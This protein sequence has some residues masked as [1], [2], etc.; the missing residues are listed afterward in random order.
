MRPL[1]AACCVF[2]L[3]LPLFAA[4]PLPAKTTE[5]VIFADDRYDV[6]GWAGSPQ[7]SREFFVARGFKPLTAE[8]LAA[9]MAAKAAG[10]AYGTV[11]VLPTGLVPGPILEPG[12]WEGITKGFSDKK[13]F[14]NC[15]IRKYME[16]GGRVVFMG[17]V[18]FYYVQGAAG[19][20]R[21][22][23]GLMPQLADVTTDQA[24]LYGPPHHQQVLT[25]QGK[26]WG[27]TQ[28]WFGM[29][30]N[31]A[32]VTQT[33]VAAPT[34]KASLI[35]LKTLNPEYPLSGLLSFPIKLRADEINL[36]LLADI[37]KAA[38]YW[39][40]PVTV[41]EVAADKQTLPDLE[42]SVKLG[43]TG[44]R[45]VYLPEDPIAGLV[46]ITNRKEP[47]SGT[48]TIRFSDANGVYHNQEKKLGLPS[49]EAPVALLNIPT[50]GL[51]RGEY[52]LEVAFT[53]DTGQKVERPAAI[54][55][56]SK[57]DNPFFLGI[58]GELPANAFRR[59]QYLKEI[60]GYHLNPVCAPGYD[61]DLLRMGMRFV[62]RIE[63]YEGFPNAVDDKDPALLRRD[64]NGNPIANPWRPALWKVSIAHP[65]VI[66]GWSEGQR[67]QIRKLA[68]HPAWFPTILTCDD[69]SAFFG[70]DFG[71][72]SSKLFTDRTGKPVPQPDPKTKAL[73]QP[74][75]G[76]IADDDLRLLWRTHTLKDLGG[77][78]T[79]NFTAAKDQAAPLVPFGP[80]PGGMMIPVW[81][82]DQYPPA[83]FGSGGFDLLSYYYYNAY[84]QPEIGNLYWDEV[85]RMGNRNLP[86][87]STPD[88]YIAGDEPSYYRNAFFLHMAGGVSGLNYYAYSEHKDAALKEVGRLAGKLDDL[89]ALQTA[90]KPSARHVGL[91]LPMACNAMDWSYPLAAMY[92]FSNL[93]CAHVDVE[94][95][96]DEE[97]LRGDAYQ[98]EALVLWNADWLS[99]SE[100]EGLKSYMARGGKVYLDKASAVDLPGAMHL[101]VD[102][103][104]G[105]LDSQL[106]NDDPRLA[107][108][109]QADYNVPERVA[110]VRSA[111]RDYV[112]FDCADPNVIARP[113]NAEGATYLWCA[114][115]HTNEEYKY[116]V[117]RMPVYKRD[118]DRAAAE[119]EGRKFLR[120]RG[121]YDK[122]VQTTLTL[123][124]SA[125]TES[126][127]VYDVWTGKRL[128]LTRLPDGRA[129]VPVTME[130]LGGTL[131]GLYSTAPAKVTIAAFPD[132]VKRG[133]W[134]ALDVRAYGENGRLMTGLLPCRLRILDPQGHE[135]SRTT[136][137]LR[138]G[139]YVMRF[140]PAKNDVVG[141]WTVEA[142]ELAGSTNRS[143]AIEVR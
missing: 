113:F 30:A 33:L 82:G 70:E 64:E 100:A 10:G 112:G 141:K 92:A 40:Q 56:V 3:A 20:I 109:G 6:V 111:L 125:V 79:R 31:T 99:Q 25:E 117:E 65:Q 34:D 37:Y 103:A 98:Y 91:Y 137:A 72:Y 123:P 84:W 120:D 86:L 49:G 4:Q 93:T 7:A 57:P 90:L 43:E 76:I 54:S 95:V 115:V 39:G 124:A 132:T 26:Q 63:A 73:P 16:A 50:E 133:E 60:A 81:T 29:P 89:G 130:R 74:P 119:D 42:L 140:A 69:F 88:I 75:K 61:D 101:P 36:P 52:K 121:V 71:A 66:A 46:S 139:R 55:L 138:D 9:W 127:A 47:L 21:C 122:Q 35:F 126:M 8:E 83:N 136:I 27:L 104:M 44:S 114:N 11:A 1:I 67:E 48:L 77:F 51:R 96:C 17:D 2:V 24:I 94:P 53:S 58:W 134:A 107:G 62:Q 105:K 85:A 128:P 59:E 13:Q 129:T 118:K 14:A 38:N 102:L 41:P 87:W 68:D 15:A 142:T 78:I 12:G 143:A 18:T 131:L 116:L 110:A 19:P 23:G 28:P 5:A 135:T 97:L 22:S 45:S 32:D 80:V 108:P 106:N